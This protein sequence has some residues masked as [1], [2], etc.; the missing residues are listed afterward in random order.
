MGENIQENLLKNGD[1]STDEK[2]PKKLKFSETTFQ[3]FEKIH[4]EENLNF[5]LKS[6]NDF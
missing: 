2:S 4:R 1:Q 5:D 3:N 6:K